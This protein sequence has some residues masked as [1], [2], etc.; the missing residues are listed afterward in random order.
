MDLGITH[1]F[2]ETLLSSLAMSGR[3]LEMLGFDP[4]EVR[5]GID[6]FHERDKRLLDEQHA[7]HHD[8]ERLIQSAKDTARELESLLRNDSRA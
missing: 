7:I 8:E 6:T 5:R 3:V 1:I 2:R 4:E